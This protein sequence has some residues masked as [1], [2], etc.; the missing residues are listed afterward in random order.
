M[1]GVLR[2]RYRHGTDREVPLTPGEPELFRFALGATSMVFK[3]GHRLRL[4]VAGSDFPR[5]DRDPQ[6][7]VTIA[8]AGQADLRPARQTLHHDAARPSRLLLPVVGELSFG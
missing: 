6:Q 5:F 1:D 3:A 7:W 4:Q 2:A 8:T